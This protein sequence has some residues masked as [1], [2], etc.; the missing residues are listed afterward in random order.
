MSSAN[1]V[2][3]LWL[4]WLGPLL[5]LLLFVGVVGTLILCATRSIAQLDEC[6][7]S[8]SSEDQDNGDLQ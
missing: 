5:L 7:E 8:I 1:L 2:A 4:L 3:Y 6:R